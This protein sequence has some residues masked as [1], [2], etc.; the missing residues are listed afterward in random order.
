MNDD[1]YDDLAL[2]RSAEQ[3]FGVD[4]EIEKVIVRGIDF[5]TFGTCD[6]TVI[7]KRNNSIAIYTVIQNCCSTMSKK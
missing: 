7:K 4:I 1:I 5:G 3:E 2:E 6:G